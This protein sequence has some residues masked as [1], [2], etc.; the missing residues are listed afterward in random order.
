M[1]IMH[2]P[3]GAKRSALRTRIN[4]LCESTVEYIVTCQG[5]GVSCFPII[6]IGLVILLNYAVDGHKKHEH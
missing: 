6:S 3:N 1:V 4:R 2:D 5:A